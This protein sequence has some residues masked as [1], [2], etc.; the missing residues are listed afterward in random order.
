MPT[1]AKDI[2]ISPMAK[3]AL[4]FIDTSSGNAINCKAIYLIVNRFHLLY[5]Y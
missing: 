2:G 1:D 3:D 4:A 5:F